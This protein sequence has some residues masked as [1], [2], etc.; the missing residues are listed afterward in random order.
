MA[1]DV[2][3]TVSY[4]IESS[5]TIPMHFAGKKLERLYAKVG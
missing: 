4:L 1:N 2:T 5:R 3:R